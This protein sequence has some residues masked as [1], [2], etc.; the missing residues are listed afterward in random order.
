MVPHAL[1]SHVYCVHP[2][3]QTG[4]GIGCAVSVV[5]VLS[6]TSGDTVG[7]ASITIH[8]YDLGQVRTVCR[9]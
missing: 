2:E 7:F 6:V 3:I 9:E 4:I 5:P 8:S 1:S